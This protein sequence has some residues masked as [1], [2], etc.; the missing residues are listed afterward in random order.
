MQ[1]ELQKIEEV[2]Q[3]G[4]YFDNW[5]SLASMQ[6]PPWFLQAKFGIFIHWG[7]YSIPAHN[8]EWYS[9]NMYC[10][11][12]EEW[13]YHRRTYGDQKDFGYKDF[14]PLFQAQNFDANEWA[15][16]FR[17]AGA[18]YIFPVAE[19]HD[20]FQMYKSKISRYNAFEMGPHRDILGELRAAAKE[21]GLHF[22]TSSHRAEHWFFMGP[23]KQFESDIH[24]PLKRGDFYWPS[25]PE[26]NFDDLQSEPYP[27]EEYLNDWLLRTCE[28]ADNYRPELIYFDWWVQH[29][30]FKPYLQKF[31]AYYYNR[32]VSWGAPAAICYKHDGLMF[33]T[34]IPEVERG[35]FADAKPYPWQTDTA[36]ARN[37][38]CYTDSLEYK[39]SGEIIRQLID[40]VSKNGNL[41]LNVG[42]K[43]DGTIA[44]KDR[45]I[46]RE[47]GAWLR[48]NG[49]AVFGSR[50]WRK[51]AEG[52]TKT[53]EG[54]FT[55]GAETVY[56][57]DDYRF[58][59]RGGSIYAFAM[60]S[61]DDGH[62]V[63][64]SLGKSSD[65]NLPEFHGLIERVSILGEDETPEWYAD[66]EGLHIKS[67]LK[68]REL[69]VVYRIEVR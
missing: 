59:V 53:K 35:T 9:R 65:Q 60:Q 18:K 25:M 10:K 28:L 31:A 12:S 4:P 20:G 32:A 1:S 64:K 30:A 42:P 15:R 51:S 56:T 48:V 27:N 45:Q 43:A 26:G 7:L 23:G 24:E 55:D 49:E 40:I 5:D 39:S 37:S 50:V 41:L 46:L 21:N 61:P 58:T 16:I 47:I 6:V 17:D 13:T 3:N 29:E 36:I 52:P 66:G 11:D 67:C 44:E 8:N 62:S 57:K 34:G 33:G 63:I 68:A 69:P 19:H 38:W 2:I 22:C 54:Q 14:I